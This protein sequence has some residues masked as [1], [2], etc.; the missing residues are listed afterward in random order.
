MR[1]VLVCPICEGKTF[2]PFQNC[3]DYTVSQETFH[4]IECRQCQ[5]GVTSPTP[6]NISD[7]YLSDSYISHSKKATTLIDSIYLLA[8]KFTLKWKL[9]LINNHTPK[10]GDLTL[11][12]YGCGTGEFLKKCKSK[13]WTIYGIEPSAKARKQSSETAQTNIAASLEELTINNFNIIT[14]WHVLEHIPDL[15]KTIEKLKDKLSSSGTMFIAVPNHRS[16]DAK[17]YSELEADKDS[18]YMSIKKRILNDVTI[19]IIII[20]NI[21][22]AFY[23]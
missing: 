6:D 18:V 11:L 3:K 15:N 9:K 17:Y 1:E 19:I 16:W 10:S 5:F 23:L 14:L 21:Q 7:Y 20:V 12:D 2:Q 8:R 4:I 13:G 22:A